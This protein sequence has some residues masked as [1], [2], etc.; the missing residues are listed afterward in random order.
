MVS[1]VPV[2][3][4]FAFALFRMF[5][6]FCIKGYQALLAEG[7]PRANR[8]GIF[9]FTAVLLPARFGGLALLIWLAVKIGVL[10]TIGLVVGAFLLSLILQVTLGRL[11]FAA[12]GHLANL[13]SLAFLIAVPLLEIVIAVMIAVI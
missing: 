6:Y 12:F 5:E 10:P 1:D 4:I 13:R 8:T 2:G 3:L 7:L 11:L 9:I